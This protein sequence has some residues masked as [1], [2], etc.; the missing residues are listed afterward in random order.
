MLQTLFHTL[1][2]NELPGAF[3]ILLHLLSRNCALTISCSTPGNCRNNTSHLSDSSKYKQK[4][5]PYLQFKTL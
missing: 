1:L 2:N 5:K 4:N 3:Y